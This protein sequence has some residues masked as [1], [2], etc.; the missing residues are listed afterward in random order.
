MSMKQIPIIKLLNNFKDTEEYMNTLCTIFNSIKDIDDMMILLRGL[1]KFPYIFDNKIGYQC[2]IRRGLYNIIDKINLNKEILEIFNHLDLKIINDLIYHL[3]TKLKKKSLQIDDIIFYNNNIL[4][5]LDIIINNTK[6]IIK[7]DLVKNQED[8]FILK[9][10]IERSENPCKTN[11]FL[12]NHYFY[13]NEEYKK[14][15]LDLSQ[16]KEVKKLYSI[17]NII[18]RFLI[19]RKR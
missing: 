15:F 12:F 2:I 8:V 13:Y 3:I 18:K 9:C 16:Y 10:I 11:E 7:Y 19:K 1:N 4:F 14:Y 5:L 6:D 17:K